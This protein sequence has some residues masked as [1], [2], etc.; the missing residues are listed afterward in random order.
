LGIAKKLFAIIADK[1][2][3]RS[4]NVSPFFACFTGCVFGG[5]LLVT[6]LTRSFF[7]RA[8]AC[9]KSAPARRR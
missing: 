9:N 5:A 2:T 6:R 1:T 4:R 7:S 3:F 8:G